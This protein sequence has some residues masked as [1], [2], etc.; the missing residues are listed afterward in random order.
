MNFLKIFQVKGGVIGLM[1]MKDSKE[2]ILLTLTN[3]LLNAS[4][5][6]FI[7][8]SKFPQSVKQKYLQNLRYLPVIISS[9]RLFHTKENRKSAYLASYDIKGSQYG[10]IKFLFHKSNVL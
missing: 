6:L 10:E 7:F 8:F 1:G 3:Y 5:L 9:T 2:G 4:T